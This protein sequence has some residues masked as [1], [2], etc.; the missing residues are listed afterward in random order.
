[1]VADG[2]NP[3]TEEGFARIAAEVARLEAALAAETNVLL[4]ETLERDL[5]YWRDAKARA[6]VAPRPEGKAIGF[7]SRVTLMRDGRRQSF[8]IVGADE[9][10]PKNGTI[11]FRAPLAQAI[12]GAEAGDIV[13]MAQP[14]SRFSR[15][16]T[17][18]RETIARSENRA[19]RARK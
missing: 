8:R 11:S 14:R 3:V 16:R 12:L 19:R 17:E 18:P 9:A 10:D 2:P 6:V 13:E 1:M 7:G 4:R 5:R 15:S